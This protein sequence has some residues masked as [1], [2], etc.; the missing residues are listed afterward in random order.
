MFG[1][2]NRLVAISCVDCMVWYGVVLI[3]DYV[4]L[5]QLVIFMLC[6][7]GICCDLWPCH[8]YNCRNLVLASGVCTPLH[9]R[10]DDSVTARLPTV[11]ELWNEP[12]TSA[13]IWDWDGGSDWRYG[14]IRF[15]LHTTIQLEMR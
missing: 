9:W 1:S 13:G 3:V 7:S 5:N 15:E 4:E 11:P 8:F 10:K 2:M 12:T 14:I 6:C